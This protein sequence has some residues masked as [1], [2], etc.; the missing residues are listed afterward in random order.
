[1]REVLQRIA[2]GP[3][4][5]KDL[6]VDQARAAMRLVLEQK[7]DPVQS[8]LFLIALRMKRETDDEMQGVTEAILE[9]VTTVPV[10]CEALVTLVDPLRRLHPQSACITVC[11]C[12]TC[13]LWRA[14]CDSW[15][16][17]DRTKTRA[18]GQAG[19]GGC[20]NTSQSKS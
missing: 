4:M 6:S 18:L 15:Y 16:R 8:A 20:R 19:S 11:T 3:T 12:G 2:T 13:S 9:G 17:V 10:N 1:M 7:A 14:R 5:S